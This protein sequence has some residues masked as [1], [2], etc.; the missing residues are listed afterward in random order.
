MATVIL[1]LLLNGLMAL[2][3]IVTTI[4]CWRLNKR[5]KVLQDSKSELSQIIRQFDESTQRATQSI[6][7]IHEATARIAENIQHK[8]DKAN[9][10]ADD[11]QF[12][13]EKGGKIA[14]RME[15]GLSGNRSASAQPRTSAAPAAAPSRPASTFIDDEAQEA[16]SSRPAPR[17][18]E[19]RPEPAAPSGADK[20]RSTLDSVFRRNNATRN[21][22]DV[23]EAAQPETRRPAGAMR[24]AA[25]LRSKA[26]QELFDALK[27]GNDKV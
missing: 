18:P 26:E 17:R 23:I 13:I 16:M 22:D 15:G 14:D 11:L 24:P 2:L 12:M 5:I 20:S 3:L 4:Y 10:L 6:G 1:N 27:A 8:I 9:Y 19:A 7:D 21:R 25:R